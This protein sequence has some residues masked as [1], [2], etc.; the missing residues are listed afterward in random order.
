MIAALRK[1]KNDKNNA[2]FAL[3]EGSITVRTSHSNDLG[4]FLNLEF[5]GRG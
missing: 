2:I 5:E 4:N 1:Y 3:I